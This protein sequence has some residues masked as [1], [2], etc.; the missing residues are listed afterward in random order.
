MHSSRSAQ[1]KFLTTR[2]LPLRSDFVEIKYEIVEKERT[3]YGAWEKG[4]WLVTVNQLKLA[5]R[6]DVYDIVRVSIKLIET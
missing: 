4:Q 1:W 3:D 5:D 6:C 2:S